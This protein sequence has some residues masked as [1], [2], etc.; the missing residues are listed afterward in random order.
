MGLRIVGDKLSKNLFII[1]QPVLSEQTRVTVTVNRPGKTREINSFNRNIEMARADWT[2]YGM[3]RRRK[4][5]SSFY[6]AVLACCA[7][8]NHEELRQYNLRDVAKLIGIRSNRTFYRVMTLE[9]RRQVESKAK[10]QAIASAADHTIVRS[11]NNYR[12]LWG[13]ITGFSRKLDSVFKH[14]LSLYVSA[15]RARSLRIEE[16]R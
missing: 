9:G 3:T 16:A 14:E 1:K 10:L 8:F 13:S 6:R 11:V 15:M 4:F 5:R 7:Y 12:K 2:N